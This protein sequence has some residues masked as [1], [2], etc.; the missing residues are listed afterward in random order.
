MAKITIKKIW[1]KGA[2]HKTK[3]DFYQVS[4]WSGKRKLSSHIFGTYKGAKASMSATKR[5][6]AKRKA[7]ARKSRR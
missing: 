3:P 2:S 7:R 5:V 4:T 1:V 6:W